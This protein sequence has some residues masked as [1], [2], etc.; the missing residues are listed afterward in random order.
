MNENC[1]GC[2]W[3]DHVRNEPA[4]TGYCCMVER[5]S[6]YKPEDRVRYPNKK[7]CE[8]YEP[9]DFATRYSGN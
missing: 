4:G 3:L 8:L 1:A 9:G 5:A 2:K 7:R 6:G